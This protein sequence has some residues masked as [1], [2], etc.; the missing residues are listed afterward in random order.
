M[1]QSEETI[2]DVHSTVSQGNRRKPYHKPEVRHE[3]VFE[4]SALQ[5]G[6]VS[7]TQASCHASPKNS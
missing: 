5:C 2:R 1:N 6:K 7:S 4:T 3:K